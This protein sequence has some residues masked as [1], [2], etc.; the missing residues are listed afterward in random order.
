VSLSISLK[1]GW[2]VYDQFGR[3]PENAQRSTVTLFRVIMLHDVETV[4][5]MFKLN[6]YS[7][8]RDTGALSL[9]RNCSPS[10][11][12]FPRSDRPGSKPE[13]PLAAFVSRPGTQRDPAAPR[14]LRVPQ[15]YSSQHRS[16]E[17][18]VSGRDLLV[19]VA[20]ELC[21]L[22]PRKKR[23]ERWMCGCV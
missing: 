17:I 14:H 3:V 4:G 13:F 15:N 5:A 19:H 7:L 22:I 10:F 9:H 18:V 1:P 20:P 21:R 23:E 16:A 2:P 6:E 11:G 12:V 8:R